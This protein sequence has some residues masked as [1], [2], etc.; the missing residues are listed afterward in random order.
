MEEQHNNPREI[1][2]GRRQTSGRCRAARLFHTKQQEY[3]NSFD[4]IKEAGKRVQIEQRSTASAILR[5]Q[6][7]SQWWLHS[8]PPPPPQKKKKKKKKKKKGSDTLLLHIY[9]D[10]AC[11]RA[12][13][14]PLE[15]DPKP[16]WSPN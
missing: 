7:D 11:K 13:N 8:P 9:R 6:H 3:V 12:Q 1:Q 2:S 4:F 14:I 15:V 5:E 16:A 10:S